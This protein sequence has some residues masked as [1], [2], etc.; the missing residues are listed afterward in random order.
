VKREPQGAFLKGVWLGGLFGLALAGPGLAQTTTSTV[1]GRIL[2]PS[3]A[4][5]SGATVEV[6]GTTIRRE[7][8]SDPSGF[9]RAV[10]LPAGRYSVTAGSAGFK[11]KVLEGI[12]LFLNRTVTLDVSLDVATQAES[13][14]VEASAPLVDLVS[15]SNRQVIDSRTIEAIPLNGRNYLDLVLLTPGVVVNDSARSDLPPARDTRGA[16]LGERAG[17]AAFLIDGLENNDDF[18]GGV[19]QSYTQDA[20]QEFEVIDAGYKAEFGRGSGGIVNVITKSGTNETKGSAFF[21]FRDDALDASNVEGEDP[22]QLRRYN[23]GLTL[24]GPVTKDRSWYFGSFE[25]FKES[26]ASLFPPNIPPS[27]EAGEDFSR[28]PETTSYRL[29]GKYAQSFSQSNDLRLAASWTRL[30]N[31]N[32]LATATSLPSS[33]NNNVTKTFLGTVALTTIFSPRSFLESSLGYRDQRFAQNE[34]GAEGSSY[35]I[36]FLDDG[37]SFEFGPPFGSVQNLDQKYL[38][39]REVLSLFSGERHA[40][41][42]GAEYVR[43]AVDGVN[44]QGFQNVIVTVRPFFALYGQDSFQIP[45]GVGFFNPGDE[46]TTLRN[47]GISFFAQDDWRIAKKVTLNLGVRYDYDSKF[48]DADNV[49]PRAGITWNP[50]AKTVVRVNWGLFYDR[51]RLGI[52]QSVPE[53]GGFNGRTVV[54]LNYPRLT[55]DALVPF[56]GSIAAIAS[57]LRDPLFL[58]KAFGIPAN[59]VVTRGN[60]QSLTGMTPDQFLAALRSF[61][62][63]IGRP[64]VPVDFSPGTGYLRQDLAAGF[65]DV[66]RAEDP[67][68]TPHNRTFLVGVQRALLS[69]LSVGVTYVHRDIRNIL[70]LRLTNLAFE[71]RTVGAPITT[72]GGPLQRTYGAFYD[73]KYDGFI[74]AVE[75]RFRNRFQVQANYTYSRATD[76]LLNSNLGLGLATQGGGAVPTDNL[77]LEFDRG[78]SDLSV[79]HIFV[80]SGVVSLP[81]DFWMSGVVRATSGVHFTAVGTPTDY[82]GDGIVSTR[83]QGTERNQFTGPSTF[84]LD[85]RLEKR[86]HVGKRGGISF[87]VEGFNVTNSRNPR[88]IDAAYVGGQPGPNFGEVR[89]PQPGREIQ[90]GFRLQF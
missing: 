68:T 17:N 77:D 3:G 21:F 66:I 29:F 9:Y 49:A 41:K 2:D 64:F 63:G 51:Y 82:D 50:D 34:E 65:Q 53:L 5:I 58:H 28:Q 79:P 12:E 4:G 83:P 74:V 86:F 59:A 18:R 57:F 16:I 87:L 40:A 47:N 1:E 33:S 48:D 39:L 14:T 45:Q 54:E 81:I 80:L 7:L 8:A 44:G 37:S 6:K 42:V 26:R 38:T 56:P 60:I 43:T 90:L 71:S 23:S 69:D 32:E 70:G 10:A 73:G 62:T 89:V 24:G 36:F 67:F 19:F 84:N 55:A 22:P 11:T 61:L 30:E 35:S 85:L 76:N 31:L 25:H 52:A 15:S 75:K 78:N 88:L 46:L 72:D 20:I 13:V 27:L